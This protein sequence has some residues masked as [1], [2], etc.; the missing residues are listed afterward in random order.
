[1]KIK[2]CGMKDPVNIAELTALKPD[3]IG[4]IFHPLSGRYIERLGKEVLDIIP[5][6]LK[7]VGVFVDEPIDLLVEKFLK[8]KLD[9]VQLHGSELPEYCEELKSMHIPIIKSFR[10]TEYF[11]FQR[12][13]AYESCC[14][15][16]LFDTAGKLAG[17]NGT[18]FDWEL[19]AGYHGEKPFFL[20]GGIRPEDLDAI[21]RFTHPMLIGIDVNSGFE[22]D[23]GK[24]DLLKLGTFIQKL[25]S[26]LKINEYNRIQTTSQLLDDTTPRI[27]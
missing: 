4:F 26:E 16:F 21:I 1:M 8:N 6:D 22:S 7:K 9:L 12:T 15:Y 19:L 3:Y 25:R 18:K 20:S 13:R 17:G 27:E 11:N 5:C 23:P 24:K 10:I 14:D 2:V